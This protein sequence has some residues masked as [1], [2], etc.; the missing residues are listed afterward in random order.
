[1]GSLSFLTPLAALVALAGL[2][3]LIVLRGRERRARQVRETL[4]LPEPPPRPRRR[5][6]I[7]LAGVSAL[8]GVAAAQPVLDRSK[9]VRERADAEAFFVLDT[10]RSMLAAA[11]A[12]EPT[13]I[14]RGRRIARELRARIP[15]VP[16]GL[17]SLT[18]RTLPHLFPTV[19]PSAFESTLSRAI[20]IERPPPSVFYSAH[21]TD[22]CALWA[23]GTSGFFSP[24]VRKR[25]L[26]ALTDGE[27]QEL[28]PALGALRDAGVHTVFVHVWGADEAIFATSKPEP[29]YRPDP[30]SE[31]ALAQ[32]AE[33]V[34]GEVFGEDEVGAAAA[35]VRAELGT[36]P[37]RSRSRRDLLALMP[38]VTLAAVAP[39]AY[40]LRR[41]NL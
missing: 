33:V 41:R 32:A 2:L 28:R 38:Y 14:E 27:T 24:D 36:G 25:V 30:S 26:V 9:V 7:A 4:G 29:Q 23:V 17:A 35:H 16:A 5:L 18:D 3:P 6:A 10:S 22:L 1:M 34:D 37:T 40:V 8:A 12:D 19:D 20:G 39:L 13:R 31:R 15:E 21:A 11:A